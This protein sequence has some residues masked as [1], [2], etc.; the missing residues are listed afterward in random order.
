MDF[1]ERRSQDQHIEN[2]TE[3]NKI[4]SAFSNPNP[5]DEVQ[6]QSVSLELYIGIGNRRIDEIEIFFDYLFVN[7]V[8]SV[9]D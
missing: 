9:R 4:D 6:S 5:C 7:N 8:S 1:I 2:W 3:K